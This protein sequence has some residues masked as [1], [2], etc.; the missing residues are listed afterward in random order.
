V[1]RIQRLPRIPDPPRT[2]PP[3]HSCSFPLL[4]K[5]GLS[6]DIHVNWF[7]LAD[8]AAFLARHPTTTVILDHLGCPKLGQVGI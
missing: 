8:A 2:P 7:Q 5:H 1:C 4:A 6:Y 3:P